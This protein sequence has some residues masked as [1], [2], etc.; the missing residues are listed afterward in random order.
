MIPDNFLNNFIAVAETS[1][2]EQSWQLRYKQES[3]SFGLWT[4]PQNMYVAVKETL[5]SER[6]AL[7]FKGT[8]SEDEKSPKMYF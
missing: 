1:V 8:V 5:K 4:Q 2:P 7:T 3:E 6:A